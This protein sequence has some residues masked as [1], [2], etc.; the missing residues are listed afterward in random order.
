MRTTVPKNKVITSS[1]TRSLRLPT[2]SK[3]ICK[4]TN[5]CACNTYAYNARARG[6]ARSIRDRMRMHIYMRTICNAYVSTNYN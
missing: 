1:A 4:V 3:K 6:G 5:A 2:R